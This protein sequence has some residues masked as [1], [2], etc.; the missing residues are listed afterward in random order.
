VIGKSISAFD[1]LLNYFCAFTP[2]MKKIHIAFLSIACALISFSK[3]KATQNEFAGAVKKTFDCIYNFKFK[4]A[5][6]LITLL[7]KTYPDKIQPYILGTNYYWW[8][9]RSGEDN[10]DVRKKFLQQIYLTKM[11]LDKKT[12]SGKELCNEDIFDYIHLYAYSARLALV[13][14]NY[15]KALSYMDKCLGYLKASFGKENM[16]ESFSLTSGLYNF[17][18]AESKKKYLVLFPF[19]QLL[20][21]ANREKGIS[22]LIKCSE[23]Q[24]TVLCSEGRYFMMLIYNESENLPAISEKYSLLLCMEHPGNLLYQYYLFSVLLRQDKEA[25][26]KKRLDILAETG[27]RNEELNDTQKNFYLEKAKDDLSKYQKKNH[28]PK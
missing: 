23:S 3:G 27:N 21:D 10:A 20:P 8:K 2:N 25:E 14:D 12:D 6:S 24:D 4:K 28:P 15:F 17:F 16:F 11:L 19:M 9:I 22:Y 5:D 26:A 1:D 18:I 7:K 13:D